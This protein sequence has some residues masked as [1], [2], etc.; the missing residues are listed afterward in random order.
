MIR[1]ILSLSTLI[2]NDFTFTITIY[3]LG[4]RGKH[5]GIIMIFLWDLLVASGCSLRG[6]VTLTKN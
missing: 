3:Y 5:P 1:A 2:I 6:Y 4:Q